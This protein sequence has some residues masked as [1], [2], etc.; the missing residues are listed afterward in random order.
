MGTPRTQ[1]HSGLALNNNNNNK[2]VVV[3]D[4]SETRPRHPL[5]VVV[6]VDCL[7]RRRRTGTRRNKA[8]FSAMRMRIL[9]ARKEEGCFRNLQR[10][11]G[12]GCLEEEQV[13]VVDCLETV[14]NKIKRT[15]LPRAE[16]E[17]SSVEE[18]EE[19]EDLVCSEIQLE[20]RRRQEEDSLAEE[21]EA[22]VVDYLAPP[23]M[24]VEINNNNNNKIKVAA[25]LEEDNN[26]KR[27]PRCLA[28][29]LCLSAARNHRINKD[30]HRFSNNT[31][32]SIT[33]RNRSRRKR[34]VDRLYLAA[35]WRRRR[36]CSERDN[37]DT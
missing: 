35:T 34:K 7:V 13:V 6:V 2:A 14:P 11:E 17:A 19:E 26:N 24:P 4:C 23:L 30:S 27:H 20:R 29:D 25:S 31:T 8:G 15:L 28:I 9:R 22:L 33:F 16:A 36:R 12:E 37:K 5:V 18:E 10:V 3:V 32:L 21:E 1:E